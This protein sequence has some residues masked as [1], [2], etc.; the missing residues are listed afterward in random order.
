MLVKHFCKHSK[1]RSFILDHGAFYVNIKQNRFCTA[2]GRTI[3][4]HEGS[5]IIFKFSAKH[6]DRRGVSYLAVFQNVRQH[7]EEVRF[8]TSEESRDP[9]SNIISWVVESVAIIIKKTDKMFL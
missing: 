7:F 4:H 6:L 2:P 8:T 1:N 5:R 9:Y 3:D